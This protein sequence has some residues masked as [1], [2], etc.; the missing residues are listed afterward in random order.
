MD[1]NAL[2]PRAGRSGRPAG[3]ARADAVN[4]AMNLFWR[5]GFLAVSAKDLAEAMAIQRSSLYNSFGS[6][7]AVFREALALYGTQ[8]PDA[9]LDHLRPGEPAIPT[10]VSVMRNLCHLRASDGEAR[11]CLVCN[12]V[13]EL[14]GVE[15]ELG[16]LLEAA[17][18]QRVSRVERLLLQAVKQGEIAPLADPRAAAKSFTA[19]LIGLNVLSKVVRD[20][21][22]LWAT[23]RQFLLGLGVPGTALD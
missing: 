7:E 9:P 3:F 8:A 10:I 15:D 12:G 2:T 17:V 19:F 1:K 21:K 6:R 22:Q 13:A 16:P 20:E 23:C 18:K 4:A 11:G 14:V 5:R